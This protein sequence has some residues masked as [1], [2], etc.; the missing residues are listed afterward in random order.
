MQYFYPKLHTL[1]KPTI[2][3]SDGLPGYK[4]LEVASRV[5]LVLK[6]LLQ[7]YDAEVIFVDDAECEEVREIHDDD[8]VDFLL[9]ISDELEEGEEYVPPIFRSNMSRSPLYFQGGMY[10]DE[11]GTPIGKESI[12]SAL[13]SAKT[14]LKAVEYMMG[15]SKSAFAL[16]RP[17]GH[18][19]GKR[20]YGGYCFFNN[21]YLGA[22][23]FVKSG[24]KVAVIDIDYHIGD[25]SLEFASE[26]MPY[27][28]LH[29]NTHR[30]Y[31]YLDAE[32]TNTNKSVH[33]YEFETGISGKEY[34][35]EVQK[36][37]KSAIDESLDKVVLSLGFDT[38]GT[39]YTQD[40][41]IYVEAQDFEAIGE[42]FGSLSQEVLILLEGGYDSDY[43]DSCANYFMSGFARKKGL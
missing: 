27:Y 24:K 4:H 42:L 31:P 11:I 43:L 1:H 3:L 19:A 7:A 17:P 15:S 35:Q 28:S 10:C 38:L 22:N 13:N 23:S 2:D 16:T 20:R 9:R 8:Y 6:G 41:Y 26:L 18:H 36:L 25:G 34:I 32:F 12:K 33:L 37:L 30:N 40:E 14:T 29:A 39:D 5:E 21:A